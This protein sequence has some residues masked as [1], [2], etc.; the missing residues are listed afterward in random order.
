M[1][2]LEEELVDLG[3]Y[4]DH[5]DGAELP[6]AVRRRMAGVERHTP[7]WVKVAAAIIVALA[8]ALAVPTSRRALAR[9][10]GIGAVEI[11][12]VTSTLPPGPTDRTVPGSVP[13]PGVATPTEGLD[14]ARKRLTFAPLVAGSDAGPVVGVETDPRVPG[15]LVVITY[16][17]FTLVEL[18]SDPTGY[19][20]MGKRVTPGVTVRRIDVNGVDALWIDGAHEIAYLAPDGSTRTDTVRRSGSVL[21]WTA[22]PVTLRIEGITTLEE[23]R[24]IAET[25]H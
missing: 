19:L 4:L 2:P 13:P 6:A 16:Q 3:R 22:G 9:L 24:R 11:R 18:A 7:A 5:G 8:V 21:L 20:V 25:V 1:T 12:P 17:R 10:L 15:G 14:E 23:A